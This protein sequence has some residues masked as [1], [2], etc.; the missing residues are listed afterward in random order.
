MPTPQKILPFNGHCVDISYLR[1]K[2]ADKLAEI[3]SAIEYRSGLKIEKRENVVLT[4]LGQLFRPFEYAESELLIDDTDYCVRIQKNEDSTISSDA[5]HMSGTTLYGGYMR[6]GWGHFLMGTLGRLWPLGS[7]LSDT[8]EFETIL[9]FVE[10]EKDTDPQG[11]YLEIFRLLGV[12][13]KVKI[14]YETP[15]CVDRLLVAEIGFEHDCFYSE[16]MRR[17]F[18]LISTKALSSTTREKTD[19]KSVYLTRSALPD[20]RKNEIGID[21]I[22]KLFE[23][24]GFAVV[25]PEKTD[26]IE[27]IGMINGADRIATLS[28]SLAHNLVFLLP[29]RQ[30][31]IFIIERHGMNNTFQANINLLGRIN[32]VHVDANWMPNFSSS[33]HR[34]YI[35]GMTPQLRSF[36][37]DNDLE[38][39]KSA[40]DKAIKERRR[41]LRKYFRRYRRYFGH[42]QTI[43]PWEASN[44]EAIA[45]T[46][47]DTRRYFGEWLREYKPLMWYDYLSPYFLKRLI[48]R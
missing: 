32:A 1:A 45:E 17:L 5:A 25:S 34:V 18:Q 28:G 21:R 38:Y 40:S 27:F 30:R 8:R 41:D 4:P 19:A 26:L 14:V 47:Y 39:D 37:A 33:S 23:A 9:F 44:A 48:K 29:D 20:A 12:E 6:S 16:E 46:V 7:E 10:N 13:K 42:A 2:K 22:D 11:N 15:V 35:Y 43:E 24:N 31:Q 36:A 3:Y